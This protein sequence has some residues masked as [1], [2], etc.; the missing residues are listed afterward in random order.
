VTAGIRGS[1]QVSI[2]RLV[3]GREFSRVE[4]NYSAFSMSTG[5]APRSPRPQRCATT[6][7][8]AAARN[9]CERAAAHRGARLGSV[10]AARTRADGCARSLASHGS[11]RRGSRSGCVSAPTAN[12]GTSTPGSP[13][14][15]S[16]VCSTSGV[17][18][19]VAT[20]EPNTPAALPLTHGSPSKARAARIPAVFSS[21]I[22]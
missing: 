8:H 15:A 17:V 14:A 12:W 11:T 21:S 9:E 20:S 19:P 7:P 4:P 18:L 6:H 10:A 3:L 16:S 2:V 22:A 5:R 13:S 1:A